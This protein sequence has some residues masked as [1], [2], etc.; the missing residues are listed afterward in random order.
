M[1]G[2]NLHVQSKRS[3]PMAGHL[4]ATRCKLCATHTKFKILKGE[5]K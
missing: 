2:S 4:A 5:K 3:D 1:S